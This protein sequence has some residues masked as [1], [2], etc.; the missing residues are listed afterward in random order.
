MFILDFNSSSKIIR[1][2]QYFCIKIVET[3]SGASGCVMVTKQ[4]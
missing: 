2:E 3:I 1:G 4:D